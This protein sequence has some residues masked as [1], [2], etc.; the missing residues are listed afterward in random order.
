[1]K[2][3]VRLNPD[4]LNAAKYMLIWVLEAAEKEDDTDSLTAFLL[5]EMD[6]IPASEE[7]IGAMI[8]A[9]TEGIHKNLENRNFNKADSIYRKLCP[10]LP[11]ERLKSGTITKMDR[12]IRSARARSHAIRGNAGKA[13][14]IM[15]DLTDEFP[16]NEHVLELYIG[17][18]T[19]YLSQLA[20]RGEY[21]KLTGAAKKIFSKARGIPAVEDNYAR[22][23]VMQVMNTGM[24]RTDSRKAEQLLLEAYAEVP[25]NCLLSQA[26]ASVY[27]EL[28]MAEIRNTRSYTRAIE[29][30]QEGLKYDPDNHDLELTE[31]LIR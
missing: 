24:Y 14:D 4:T 16:E 10:V 8:T 6:T 5:S 29:L 31:D 11:E 7:F 19:D 27:R 1:M 21:D 15:S 9:C 26:L 25:Q 17:V 18:G 20:E 28:G 2:T 23:I 13:F 3:A 12:V 30:L 22:A